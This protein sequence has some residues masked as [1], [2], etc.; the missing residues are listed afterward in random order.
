MTYKKR[1]IL[2]AALVLVIAAIMSVTYAERIISTH[3]SFETEGVD[4]SIHT[5]QDRKLLAPNMTVKYQPVISYK[6]VDAYV[7]FRLDISTNDIALYQFKGLDSDWVQRDGYFYYKKPVKHNTRL[8]TFKSFHV[9]SEYDELDPE[10]FMGSKFNITATCDAVQAENFSPDFNS[11]KP[12]GNLSIQDNGYDG[13]TYTAENNDMHHKI[14]LNFD[15]ASQHSISSDQ[16]VKNTILPGDTYKNSIVLSNS[17]IK[18]MK[19]FFS[20]SK[21]NQEDMYNLLDALKLTIK[22][23]G[24]TFYYGTLR[25]SSLNQWKSLLNMEQGSTHR[26]TYEIH[27]PAELDNAYEERL[28]HFTWNFKV[29]ED[30]TAPQTGDEHLFLFWTGIFATDLLLMCVMKRRNKREN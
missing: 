28:N 18:N 1:M 26:L 21:E 29:Q 17:G 11:D 8:S 16:M 3:G 4:V 7:R 20:V 6:G 10:E 30:Q 22:L 2:L 27:A 25:A 19:V 23:D 24:K 13:N 5:T 14:R 15:T 9:P 12:W